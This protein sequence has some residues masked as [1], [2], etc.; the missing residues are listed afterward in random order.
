[1]FRQDL[2]CD[3]GGGDGREQWDSTVKLA[4]HALGKC[5]DLEV[6]S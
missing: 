5:E 2:V 3:D 4:L 6:Q 1:M